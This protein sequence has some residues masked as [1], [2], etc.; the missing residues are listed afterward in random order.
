MNAL[1]HHVGQGR[2]ALPLH[3]HPSAG[4]LEECPVPE[5]R[6]GMEGQG[7]RPTAL[8]PL[9]GFKQ[10]P[11]QTGGIGGCGEKRIFNGK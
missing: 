7:E 4:A 2:F 5:G 3:P 9:V 11:A 1:H 6:G 8:H 10:L